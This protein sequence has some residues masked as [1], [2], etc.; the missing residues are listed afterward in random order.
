MMNSY[1]LVNSASGLVENVFVWDG[2]SEYEIPEGFEAIESSL[3]G[4]G[5]SYSGG[6]FTSP[7]PVHP[8]PADILITN[9][10]TRS[11][12]LAQAANS[13]GPLQDAVDLDEATDDE[14]ALL[15]KWKQYRIAVNRV[16]V[17]VESPDWPIEPT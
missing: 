7:P 16:N 2:E 12:L 14:V 4:I 17:E 11:Y 13:M 10:A 8:T 15:K 5:W 9:T 3:A 1:M 6:E